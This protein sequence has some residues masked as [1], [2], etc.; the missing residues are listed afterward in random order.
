MYVWQLRLRAMPT[1]LCCCAHC[2]GVAGGMA[3]VQSRQVYFQP[4]ATAGWRAL[5]GETEVPSCKTEQ[6]T[7]WRGNPVRLIKFFGLFRAMQSRRLA[8]W[9]L[10]LCCVVCICTWD[11]TWGAGAS[12]TQA[13]PRC[14]EGW[15]QS[16]A[17]A[18]WHS[19][20]P[21]LRGLQRFPQLL[22]A[23]SRGSVGCVPPSR[24][25][26]PVRCR[27]NLA[28]PTATQ[29]PGV[30]CAALRKSDRQWQ[31]A[32]ARGVTWLPA[33]V[34]DSM[35]GGERGFYKASA[36]ERRQ[37]TK[38][39]CVQVLPS[40]S[41]GGAS[42]MQC[43]RP[44]ILHL[45]SPPVADVSRRRVDGPSGVPP[46]AVPQCRPLGLPASSCPAGGVVERPQCRATVRQSS[47]LSLVL[48][49]MSVGAALAVH[50]A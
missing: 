35:A 9:A 23:R 50:P 14:S 13:S 28:A 31:E 2:F 32:D 44:A 8:V 37:C 27:P 25:A 41:C 3:L 19:R 20:L 15:V 33:A 1:V 39:V 45:V 46:V 22:V 48:S 38:P 34:S 47:V 26:T 43:G 16:G 12:L 7:P 6:W 10:V 42:A 21:Q 4:G 40:C 11:R 17:K 5:A 49:R 18:G 36:R 29:P 30:G 24:V